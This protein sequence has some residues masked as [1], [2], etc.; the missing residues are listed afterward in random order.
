VTAF[1]GAVEP[2]SESVSTTPTRSSSTDSMADP[3]FPT[4]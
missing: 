4:T 2:E 3:P 1:G